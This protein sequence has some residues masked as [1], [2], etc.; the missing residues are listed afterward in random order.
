M[1]VNNITVATPYDDK[2][3]ELSSE[4]DETRV[5]YG[6]ASDKQK[7]SAK[8]IQS[9]KLKASISSSTAARRAEYNNDTKTGKTAYMGTNELVNDFKEG[10]LDLGTIAKDKLP[11]E[12]ANMDMAQRKEYLKQ[13][14]KHRDSISTSMKQLI[15]QRKAYLDK[16]LSKKNKGE[17]EKS[18]DYTIYENVKKQAAKKKISLKGNAKL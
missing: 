13:K 3:A 11:E 10:K 7:Q 4:M 5:Y 2:I 16:E 17:V 6:S 9:T 12:M 14:V 1:N 15:E 8:S 18:F